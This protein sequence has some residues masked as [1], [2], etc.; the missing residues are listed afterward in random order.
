MKP[1]IGPVSGAEACTA[2]F[3]FAQPRDQVGL[4]EVRLLKLVDVRE[5]DVIQWLKLWRGKAI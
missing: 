4:E 1:V 5:V 3:Q 2:A